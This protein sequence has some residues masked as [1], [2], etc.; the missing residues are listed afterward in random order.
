MH[1][2]AKYLVNDMAEG[3]VPA[4]CI[5]T[6][7]LPIARMSRLHSRRMPHSRDVVQQRRCLGFH[8]P[9]R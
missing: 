1:N 5:M 4:V 8:A 9:S 7:Q 3:S 2:V 6:H